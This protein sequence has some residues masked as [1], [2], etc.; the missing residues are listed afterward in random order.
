MDEQGYIA[1]SKDVSRWDTRVHLLYDYEPEAMA[2]F[3]RSQYK[4]V[5][6]NYVRSEAMVP[7]VFPN[8][9]VVRTNMCFSGSV[10]TSFAN[11]LLNASLTLKS[12]CTS[13]DVTPKNILRDHREGWPKGRTVSTEKARNTLEGKRIM[14]SSARAVCLIEGDDCLIL[15]KLGDVVITVTQV[16]QE[17][18]RLG[19]T[20]R[21]KMMP[22]CE[23][24]TS[25]YCSHI[26]FLA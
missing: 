11:G 23:P 15:V 5:V 6:K 25:E 21:D 2:E 20:I 18:E 1:I 16:K 4:E 10:L 19:F 7:T 3:F 14:S 24:E 12:L 8:E 22:S 13:F 9:F 26:S 17:H